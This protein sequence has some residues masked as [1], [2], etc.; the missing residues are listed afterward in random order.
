MEKR[1][2][3]PDG[4][5]VWCD[6]HVSFVRAGDGSVDS[7]IIVVEDITARREAE[8]ALASQTSLLQNVID[9]VADLI[10]VKDRRGRFILANRALDEGCGELVGRGTADVFREELVE[11]Y[12]SVDQEVIRTGEHRS[13]EEIIPIRGEEKLFQTVKVPW[14][15]DG[16]TH[17]I[18]GVSRDITA[19]NAAETA[20]RKSE[21]LHRSVLDA[22]AD[23]IM[24]LDA[25]GRIEL[26]NR[27]GREIMEFGEEAE[28][29]PPSW[30]DFWPESEREAAEAALDDARSGSAARFAGFCPTARGV[31][32]YWDVVVT[33]IND[34]AGETVRLLSIARDITSVREV[35]EQLRQA[36]ELDA[37][38]NLPNRR[39]FQAHLQ[40]ATIRAMESKGN[41]GLI[42]I[43][44]D[45]FKHVNDTL[46]HAAGDHL[47]KT[48]AERLSASV[49]ATD[50]VARL[51]GDEFAIVLEGIRSQEDV[52]RVG[53]A[54]AQ[55]MKA[56][57]LFD[58]RMV[59]GGVSM[60]GAM[61]PADGAS[62]HE[63]FKNADT[64]L[65]ALKGAGRGGTKMFHAHMREQAQMVASQLSLARTAISSQSVVPHYQ[66][67][68]RLAD[69][70]LDG[71]E[72]LLRWRH[73]RLGIQCPDTVAEAF[74]DY[75]LAS[76]IGSLMQA[77]VVEDIRAWQAR[78]LQFG[79]ISINAAP[80]EFLRDDYAERL[81]GVLAK[82]G[83]AA[84][85][86]EVEVTEHVFLE[87]GSDF[88]ARALSVLNEAG[89]RVA[90]DD[91]GTGYSS[92]S[93]LRD[94]PVDVVKIDKSFIEKMNADSEIAAIVAAVIDLAHS[95][96]IE[97]VGEG[98]E[99]EAQRAFLAERGCTLGQ[100]YLFGRAVAADEVALVRGWARAA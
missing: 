14:V 63:L 16:E 61:F 37:L 52:L 38:T 1:Y 75:Q 97:V 92:L 55:R 60:G 2:V 13:V 88:V 4:S 78:G 26:I 80:A 18:I 5:A 28:L 69:G 91:F 25:D 34:E 43:D 57:S 44:V 87:R 95:L 72:A 50:L 29:T 27:P 89:V 21:A 32:K 19:R 6:I 33:P 70:K 30:S 94:F 65:Y 49:R 62:A 100:G 56:P 40:A 83:V 12:E 73:P 85:L 39:S 10:F 15:M 36:S 8:Q 42:L 51:G 99:T 41:V 66:P 74:K 45:H 23:C 79:R 48:F 3:R 67:K 7:A 35:A 54:V 24:I 84:E 64:A 68:V 98:I 9:S 31:P 17:G 71:F 20:L 90:L 81:L 77:K 96:N 46:G 76:H 59:S 82:G 58:G 93:H 86:I 11:T 22:S 53:E 47:L